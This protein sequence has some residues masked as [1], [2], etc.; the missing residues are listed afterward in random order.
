MRHCVPACSVR[1]CHIFPD[2]LVFHI[3][4]IP[5]Y[6]YRKD[7]SLPESEMQFPFFRDQHFRIDQQLG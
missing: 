6:T 7:P 5:T 2:S 4:G 3:N 1:L